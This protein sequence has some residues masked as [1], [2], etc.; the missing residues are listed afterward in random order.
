MDEGDKNMGV[1]GMVM[2]NVSVTVRFTR[3]TDFNRCTSVRVRFG[4][5]R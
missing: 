5:H 3:L 4:G 2:V 1:M